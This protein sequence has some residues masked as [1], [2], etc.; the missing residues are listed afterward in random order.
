MAV[1]AEVV[2]IVDAAGMFLPTKRPTI[3]CIHSVQP[4]VLAF[5]VLFCKANILKELELA[6]AFADYHLQKREAAGLTPNAE[7]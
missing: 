1:A 6:K 3:F 7:E 2:S 5:F 4:G